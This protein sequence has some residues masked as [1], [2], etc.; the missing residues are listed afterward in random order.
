MSSVI[1]QQGS[2]E[3]KANAKLDSDGSGAIEVADVDRPLQARLARALQREP[4][5]VEVWP[6]GLGEVVVGGVFVTVV[7]A[8]VVGGRRSS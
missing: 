7:A 3:Y 5:T 6:A 8:A 4:L 2:K 1:F